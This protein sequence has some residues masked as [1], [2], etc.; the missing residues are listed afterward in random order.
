M[1]N[2]HHAR[3]TTLDGIVFDSALEA[4]RY[5]QLKLLLMNGDITDLELQPK[6]PI[7]ITSLKTGEQKQVAR[8][9]AD[10]RYYDRAA[11]VT[12]V[13]DTKG[14]MTEAATLRIKIVQALYD[15]EIVLVRKEDV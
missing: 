14:V 1:T 4:R 8:Y 3:K 9:T 13:E 5:S 2:K 15:V 10:F 6:Y 11:G 7:V 12:V